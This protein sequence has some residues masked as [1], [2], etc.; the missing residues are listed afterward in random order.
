MFCMEKQRPLKANTSEPKVGAETE[1]EEQ[2]KLK[3][4]KHGT[5]VSHAIVPCKCVSDTQARRRDSSSAHES[6]T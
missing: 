2:E 6:D 5:R 1:T 3:N 4:D